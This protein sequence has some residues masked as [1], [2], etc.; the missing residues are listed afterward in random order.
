MRDWLGGSSAMPPL[1]ETCPQPMSRRWAYVLLCAMLIVATVRIADT[2]RI[3]NNTYDESPH[4]AAGMQYIDGGK[5]TYEVKHPPMRAVYALGPRLTGAG[6]SGKPTILSEGHHIL[7]GRGDYFDTLIA[8]RVAALPFF[9]AT[10]IIIF[11]WGAHLGGPLAG[12]FA[13]TVYTTLPLALAHAGLATTDT[14]VTAT[15]T[16]AL[17][18]WARLLSQPSSAR[19]LA[20]GLTMGLAML[21]KFSAIIFAAQVVIVTGLG[22]LLAAPGF[23]SRPQD[24]VRQR[25]PQAAVAIAGASLTCAVVIWAGYGFSTA[26]LPTLAP[27][28]KPIGQMPIPAPEFWRGLYQLLQ[29][30]GA[31]HPAFFM[32][33]VRNH[34]HWAFFPVAMLVKTPIPFLL[35]S[36]V[37]GA[38]L[39]RRS[40]DE[41]CPMAMIPPVAS[42]LI[43]LISLSARI[44]IGL[45]HLL[46]IF[47]LLAICVGASAAK[48]WRFEGNRRPFL[49]GFVALML[50]WHIYAGARAHPDYLAYFNE[51]CNSNPERLLVDSDLDWGQDLQRLSRRLKERRVERLHLAYFGTADPAFHDLPPYTILPRYKPVKGWVAISEWQFAMGT[52]LPNDHYR[53]LQGHRPVE[54]VGRSIRLYYIP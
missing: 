48:F 51:C 52:A 14:L 32:G 7:Y 10:V 8:A 29:H 37:G 4:I 5:Y 13:A 40:V 41:N 19:I 9:I 18:A 23:G 39:V 42:A 35:L 30:N 21:S 2:Y 43:L 25:L 16:A 44:N 24:K 33:S 45:R 11:W 6:Y 26:P 38:W 1:A 31:G 15:L 27:A 46:P 49:R 36:A 12:A 50:G 54:K 28:L 3:L 22:W 53:W 47:P 20:F 34:G 17:F